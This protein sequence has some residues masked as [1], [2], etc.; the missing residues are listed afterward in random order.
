MSCVYLLVFLNMY[1]AGSRGNG[2]DD[3]LMLI[4]DRR[5]GR[6]VVTVS[7]TFSLRMSN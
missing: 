3:V 4:S 7:C 5:R 6:A 2:F 1:K